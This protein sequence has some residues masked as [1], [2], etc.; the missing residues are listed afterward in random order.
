MAAYFVIGVVVMLGATAFIDNF[1]DAL[2]SRTAYIIQLVLGI[3]LVTLSYLMDPGTKRAKRLAAERQAAGD[4]TT[5]GK[6]A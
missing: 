2:E 5:Q 1:G 3:G 6:N 4:A